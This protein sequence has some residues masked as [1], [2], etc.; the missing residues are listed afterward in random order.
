MNSLGSLGRGLK[1]LDDNVV[2]A[3]AIRTADHVAFRDAGPLVPDSAVMTKEL[4]GDHIASVAE[5]VL[6]EIFPHMGPSKKYVAVQ[7]QSTVGMKGHIDIVS[8][9]DEVSKHTNCTII[10]FCAG[11]VPHHDS[12]QVLQ[13]LS[14]AMNQPSMVYMAENVWKVVALVSRAEAVL[15]TSL[16]VRIMAFIYH[17]PRFTWCPKGGKQD[18]FIRLWDAPGSE[19]CAGDGHINQHTWPAL[20]KHFGETYQKHSKEKYAKAVKLYLEN[21]EMWSGSI[22]GV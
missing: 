11:T 20:S 2:C 9:L 16:H 21:F 6:K 19:P 14:S 1:L 7:V 13:K 10:F 5:E 17:K 12:F 4:Y 22:G 3:E 8:A 15:S 18:N